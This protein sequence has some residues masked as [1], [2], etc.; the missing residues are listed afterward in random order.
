MPINH[1]AVDI[2]P[3]EALHRGLNQLVS[4]RLSKRIERELCSHELNIPV[5]SSLQ[6]EES[7]EAM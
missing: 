7:D 4:I 5:T 1:I 6:C 2:I 3:P